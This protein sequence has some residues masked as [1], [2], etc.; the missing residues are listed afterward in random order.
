MEDSMTLMETLRARGFVEQV[1]AE[2]ALAERFEAG[3]MTAYIGFDPTAD[4]LHCGSLLPLM[5]FAHLQRAGHRVIA[6]VGGGTGLIGDPSGKT[7]LRKVLTREHIARNLAGIR[8]QIARYVDMEGDAGSIVDNADWLGPLNYIGF[9]RDVGRCF[10]V[11]R[12]LAAKTYKERYESENGLNFIEFNYQLLQAYDF[13]ELFRREGCQLQLGGNDQWGNMC[14]GIDLIRRLEGG[15]D[16]FALTWPLLTTSTGAKMGKTASGAVWLDAER[17]S[18]DAFY[19]FWRNTTD[20]D[21]GRF[22]KLFTFVELEEIASLTSEGGRALN[23]AK[24]LLA[25]EATKL[26]HGEAAAE[27][28]RAAEDGAREALPTVAVTRGDFSGEGVGVLDVFTKV[29]GLAGSN[30]EVRRDLKSGGIYVNDV[31]VRDLGRRVTL[32][33]FDADGSLLLR[34]GKKKRKRLEL[35]GE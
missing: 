21:V 17:T 9:L 4:S 20:A 11:N 13:L 19:Q 2:G 3:S 30:G 7:E 32:T 28:A 14:A 6:V 15:E 10:T 27:R 16:A 1:S 23:A 24:R 18:A 29:A 31:V 8:S 26:C 12:M 35:Q 5:A 25:F 34:R 22:L 33:D